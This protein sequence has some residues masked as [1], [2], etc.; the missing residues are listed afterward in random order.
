MELERRSSAGTTVKIQQMRSGASFGMK[1][2]AK[3]DATSCGDS[4]DG[5]EVDDVIG[6]VIQSQESAAQSSRELICFSCCYASSR[7]EIQSLEEA[8]EVKRFNQSKDSVAIFQQKRERSSSRLESAAAKQLTIYEELREL[9]IPSKHEDVK[10][11]CMLLVTQL[12][13]MCSYE[14]VDPSEVEEGEM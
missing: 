3:E 11:L 13:L 10:L 7:C 4:A 14:E 12:R 8:D 5:L 9:D 1:Q 6:D 2:S